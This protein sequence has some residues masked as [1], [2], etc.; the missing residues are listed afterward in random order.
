MTLQSRQSSN[1]DHFSRAENTNGQTDPTSSLTEA[2]R[3]SSYDL[4][5]RGVTYSATDN[6]P[7]TQSSPARWF[8]QLSIRRKLFLALLASQLISVAGLV[9]IG[10]WLLWREG[11]VQTANQAKSELAVLDI[12]YHER[13]D[14][15]ITV[16]QS[17]A[18]D[19]DVVALAK[20]EA[21]GK[22]V[23]PEDLDRL[24]TLL[25]RVA[26]DQEFEY[27]TLVS[28]DREIIA[29]ANKNRRGDRFDPDGLVRR[30]LENPEVI[31]RSGSVSWAELQAESAPLP[32]GFTNQN[33]LIEYVAVP[34]KDPAS[35]SVI[36]VLV[37][38][39]FANGQTDEVAATIESL[40][41]G[42][43]A[44]Y[45]YSADRPTLVVS[46]AQT[47]E[48]MTIEEIERKNLN[49]AVLTAAAEA[50]GQIVT[51]ETR[52]GGRSYALAAKALL[53]AEKDPVGIL[54]RATPQES[55]ANLLRES[56]LLQL[57]V[58]SAALIGSTA[59]ALRLARS[60]V[61]PIENLRRAHLEFTAGDRQARAQVYAADEIGE[62]TASF[63][64]LADDVV[65]SESMLKEQ[66]QMQERISDRER[67][68]NRVIT[69][70]RALLNRQDVLNMAVQDIRVALGSDRVI[71]YM[72]DQNWQ[73]TIV[74]ESVDQR[75]PSALGMTIADPCFA[76]SF[77]EKY[78]Q[79]RVQATNN[80]HNAGLTACHLEQLE[81]LEVKANLVAP[82]ME[83]NDLVG[84]LIAHQCSATR[85]WQ[86]E[87]SNFLRQ[88]GF[89]L[90]YALEQAELYEQKETA[91]LQAELLSEE[92]RS[93][94]EA[95]QQQLLMLLNDVEGVSRGDLTVRAEVTAGE[96]G[97]VADFFNAVVE[98]LREIV[99]HVKRSAVQVS[100]ALGDNE[101]AVQRLAD[102]AMQQADR[103]T[104][105]LDS[106]EQMTRSIQVVADSAHQTA[107]VAR[108]ASATAESGGVAMDRTVQHILSLRQTIGETAKKVKRLGESSQQIA[109]VVSLINQIALQTNLLAINAGIEAA[110][111][112]E[113]GQGF[114][115]VA[116]E[117]GELAA[118]SAAATQEIEKIVETIQRETSHVVDSMEQS[119]AQVVEGTHLV[120]SA[121]RSLSQIL[122]V[123]HQID[124]LVQSISQ[125][126]VSQADTSKAVS[127]LMQE[128][129]QMSE[130][131]SDSS[132][133]V[134]EAI[135]QTVSVAQ[136]LRASVEMFEVGHDAKV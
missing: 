91:R 114:G 17:L 23:S 125:A 21:S 24:R 99:T 3:K 40:G 86:P 26:R 133:Q 57:L 111:A 105:M 102:E 11:R 13:A 97:T 4:Q 84:L 5:Y 113:E 121:K 90:G 63:N 34:V 28:I 2:D 88:M 60:I 106:V 18:E 136:D 43:S 47:S 49:Q 94:K 62:L 117:I 76:T 22:D 42:Y 127:T 1:R 93:Q 35:Q 44:V 101:G 36:G 75:F 65:L 9:G 7:M 8:Y 112:G 119:T 46:A 19:N 61:R 79:G 55:L 87:E 128:V 124:Q 81:P 96:I 53:N 100:T 103:T 31:Q 27:L 68:L 16:W 32:K 120:E 129:S 38:G 74:A 39:L 122:E 123:S 134:S 135:R 92:Q 41:S 52:V 107:E 66:N 6:T 56:L 116:E 132:R 110:R 104:E 118:R 29:N 15:L 73:G 83:K 25:R 51:S 67:K 54:V 48:G 98:S 126:T 69:R 33:A 131:T 85:Q 130:R 108:N 64:E 82:L 50:D 70:T 95:L 115:V 109:K 37:A 71:V 12:E 80:I 72:F 20:E 45:H 58:G 30:V 10:S 14:Q 78:R 59:L 77:V 89:H